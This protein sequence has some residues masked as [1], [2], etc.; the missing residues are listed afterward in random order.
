[1][2]KNVIII[3][4]SVIILLLVGVGVLLITTYSSTS[5]VDSVELVSQEETE[6][7]I[8]DYL[9]YSEFIKPTFGG[10][11]FTSIYAL[12]VSSTTQEYIVY[13]WAYS[14]EYYQ[15][16]TTL[17]QGVGASGP[18]VIYM[19]PDGSKVNRIDMP[20]NGRQY[21]DDVQRLFP[22]S[23]LENQIF[24][25]NSEFHNKK[26]NEL[27]LAVK[28][29]AE[30][31]YA[32]RVK[33]P[34]T[35][36]IVI[37]ALTAGSVVNSPLTI[38]GKAKTWYFEGSFPV[39]VV[40]ANGNVLAEAPAQAQGEWMTTEFVPFEVTLSFIPT[41]Q[42][43]TIVFQKDNPSGLPDKNEEYQLP[44]QFDTT[45]QMVSLNLYYPNTV[46]A[47]EVGDECSSASVVSVTRTVPKS[48]TPLA[49]TIALLLQGNI[50]QEEKD[51]GF[52]T[53]FPQSG[54]ELI[55]ANIKDG[56][57]ILEFSEVP[58]FTS[59]GACR[60]ELLRAQVEKTA[61]QFPDVKSVKIVPETIFQP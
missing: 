14:Q 22:A 34:V 15:K 46:K 32:G 7:A 40:D 2:S 51:A 38:T 12:G 30:D 8:G 23:I 35:T 20:N 27:S 3:L 26:I 33:N 54:F 50:T 37:D 16:D 48:I 10:H 55:S 36:N 52:T 17:T 6:K 56:V 49:D 9:S 24:S 42:Q 1:M 18:L 60:V 43:G 53:E 11:V 57:A 31:F 4:T 61:L 28:K 19:K 44:V 41:T 13:A 29:Q 47:Q 45:S 39:K 58:G 5:Q 21:W 25:S 59:G